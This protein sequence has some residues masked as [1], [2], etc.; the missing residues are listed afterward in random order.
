MDTKIKLTRIDVFI[1]LICISLF[2]LAAGAVGKRGQELNKRMICSSNIKELIAGMTN[3]AYE[4]N[5]N[6]PAGGGFWPCD[7]ANS[8]YRSI[9]RYMGM[10][11]NASQPRIPVQGVFFC[12][13]NLT[14]Q[15]G[16]DTYWYYGGYS[17]TGYSWL[18]YAPWNSNGQLP[19]LGSGNKKWVKTIYIEK[20]AET[21]LIVD[22]LISQKRIYDPAIYPNGNFGQITVGGSPSAGLYDM[23]NHIKTLKEPYGGNVGFVDGHV[24]WRSF[25]QMQLRHITSGNSPTGDPRW[26]W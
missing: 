24:Q 14:K 16:R 4:H 25:E 13:S 23:S 22:C 8:T 6:F 10:T 15:V 2:L 5:G 12:P 17:V 18:W 11:F 21:E 1:L 20:P 9:L 3:Y 19:I 26:W 7:V